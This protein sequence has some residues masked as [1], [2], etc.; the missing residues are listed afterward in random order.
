MKPLRSLPDT[1]RRDIRGVF[2]D[3]DD[4][5]TSDGR[6]T[7]AAYS[8]LERLQKSEKLV[9]PVTGRPAGW[10]DHIARMWPIHGIVG[11]NGAFYFHYDYDARQMTRR[12]YLDKQTIATNLYKLKALGNE[13]IAAV[14]GAAIASD[15]PYRETDLAIDFCE[16]VPELSRS[17]VHKIVEMMEAAGMTTKVSSIHV[18]GWF[19]IYDK[20]T[21]IDCFLAEKFG[22]DLKEERERYI[23]IGD[24]PNDQPAFA[25]FPHAVGVANVVD[26]ADELI[27]APAYL[28]NARAGEGFAELVSFL[29]ED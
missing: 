16:D 26:F 23:F 22:V 19:G 14:S 9:I 20:L 6:L 1:I 10:C 2:L 29:L 18:N 15:Q 24:S 12:Y 5:L 7:A 17:S 4:T 3:I 25:Y 8:A 11:E 13:I 28:T 27:F 21:M